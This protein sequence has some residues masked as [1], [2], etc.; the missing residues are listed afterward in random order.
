MTA[1]ILVYHSNDVN[2]RG[3][4]KQLIGAEQGGTYW[5]QFVLCLRLTGSDG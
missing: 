3:R 2:G 5:S 1:D 4:A